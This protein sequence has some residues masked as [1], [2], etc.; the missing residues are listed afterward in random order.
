MFKN[1][2]KTAFRN[3]WKEKVS[4]VINLAGLATGMACC[5]LIMVYIK[6]ELSFN[7]FNTNYTNIY[8]INW[9]TRNAGETTVDAVTPIIFS[10][11]ISPKI[12]GIQ[13]AARLYQRSGEVQAMNVGNIY[14]GRKRFQEVN[15]FFA[16]NS[17]FKI[18]SIPFVY[19][20]ANSAINEPN[21]IVLT[22]EMAAKYFGKANPVGKTLL[23]ENKQPLLVTGVVKKMPDNSD[24]KF[25]FLV[26]FETLFAV[27]TKSAA[28]FLK[29]DW[30]FNTASTYFLLRPGENIASIEHQLNVQLKK[31]GNNRNRQMNTVALQPL[32]KMHL[33]A[34]SVQGNP[35]TNSVTYIYIFAAIA[36][37][38]LF[39]A[40]I[41]FINLSVARSVSRTREVGMR[42]VMGASRQQLIVQF[43]GE[44][45]LV[46]F[47][48]F[49]LAFALAETGLPLLNQLTNK[50]LP[51]QLFF[52]WQNCLLFG[53]IFFVTGI[54]A[55]LYPAFFITRFSP[56]I[57]VKGKSGEK[58]QRN[59]VRK[60]LLVAQFSISIIL[61]IGAMVIWQQLQYLRDKPLGFQKQQMLVVPIFGSGVTSPLG[62]GVDGPMRLRMNAFVNELSRNSK[63]KAVTSASAM[64]GQG[65][66][67]GLVVPQGRSDR[68]NIFVPW[69]S[70]DYN[71]L[72]AVNIPLVAGRGFSKSTGTDHLSAFI[73]NE[74][75]VRSFGWK[76]PQ[77]A[78]GK[79]MIRGDEQ[80][81]KKGQVI[82]VI[83][84]FDFNTLD[85]PMQPLIM[86]VNAPRFTQFAINIQADHL[87]ATIEYIRQTWNKMFPERVFEYSFLDNDIDKLYHDKE[88]LGSIIE[89]F[90][91]AAILLSCC[92][93]Y[94]LASFLSVQRTKE[95]GIRKVLGATVAGIFT[96]LSSDFLK[97]VFIAVVIATPAAWYI[98]ARWLQGFAY[99]INISWWVFVGAGLL[100]M[101]TALF[102]VS[103]E[104][105]K[106]ALMNPVRSLRAE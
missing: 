29:T 10:P 79:T 83:K 54:I 37:L 65:Y 60:T 103:F 48:A 88:N 91:L 99:R 105:V 52:S 87:P 74:S 24:I 14:D 58:R 68:D 45:L 42:K 5:M 41:N 4:T 70:V 61:I 1:Y 20:N 38:I 81:G 95:I 25:D 106:A 15:V 13:Y 27:E 28:D 96:L 43:I 98:M 77:D 3:L 57:A 80:R 102:T 39:I 101:I 35:S 71:F 72:D 50:L 67:Q 9:I 21:T 44:T 62:S 19:G 11:V 36:L 75:A 23:F 22:D 73:L 53:C 86:D 76:S 94:C 51:W 59:T 17:L 46:S 66:V 78:I 56:A 26:S 85:Q 31:N 30:T 32:Q 8:S 16:D 55:G 97:L 12:T 84:D 100:V 92:G 34:A 69:V 33:Y 18:F 47:A 93:L 90:A 63:I 7:A 2:F 40:N 89:Y 6:D 104:A 82:G 64:P 49:V